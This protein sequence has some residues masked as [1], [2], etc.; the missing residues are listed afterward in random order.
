M[1]KVEDL[2]TVIRDVYIDL[3]LL[4]FCVGLC[5]FIEQASALVV[6]LGG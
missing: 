3:V 4:E 5:L 6:F 2:G 1:G